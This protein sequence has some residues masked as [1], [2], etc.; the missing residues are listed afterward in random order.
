MKLTLKDLEKVET[1]NVTTAQ[2]LADFLNVTLDKIIKSM[3]LKVDDEYVMIL[4]RG[5]HEVNDVKLKSY[6]K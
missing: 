3:I 2:A 1:P 6:F 4:I 5:H